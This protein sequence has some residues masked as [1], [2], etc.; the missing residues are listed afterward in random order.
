MLEAN[1]FA[2]PALLNMRKQYRSSGN[3]S[4][5]FAEGMIELAEARNLGGGDAS[6]AVAALES[7]LADIL[8]TSAQSVS[9]ILQARDLSSTALA[10]MAI[11]RDSDERIKN[12]AI[13]TSLLNVIAYKALGDIGAAFTAI[14][15]HEKALSDNLDV[16]WVDTIPLRRQIVLMSQRESDFIA[17]ANDATKYRTTHPPEYYASVK[18]FFE[19]LL[20][21]RKIALA[22]ATHPAFRI[23]YANAT[24]SFSPLAH[25][26]LIKNT[27]Q[28]LILDGYPRKGTALL[29]QALRAA[30]Q[31]NMHGQVRQINRLINES[32]LGSPVLESFR[33]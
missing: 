12:L 30:A 24:D 23:A 20:N 29:L 15:N 16:N 17:L 26:S 3:P 25:V 13:H 19:Y 11:V 7:F 33:V 22:R 1:Q 14:E 21:H 6:I 10:R 4:A 27:G 18:R 32:Q 31:F 28:F 2:G 8:I 5:I 9:A